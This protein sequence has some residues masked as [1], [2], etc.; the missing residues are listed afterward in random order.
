MNKS[1][2]SAEATLAQ[3][4]IVCPHCW[5]GFYADKA[6]FISRHGEL[7]GDSVLG[8]AANRR[9]SLHEV[10]RDRAGNALD[11]KGWKMLERA[12]PNCHLQIPPELLIRRP[13]FISVV[14]AARLWE[15]VLFDI[16]DSSFEEGTRQKLWLLLE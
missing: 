2:E 16:H 13:F 10:Q 7:K 11:S 14:G 4:K 15:N 9:F 5:E 8:P 6:L 12:C 3:P 1:N